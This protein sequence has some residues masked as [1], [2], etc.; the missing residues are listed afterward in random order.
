MLNEQPWNG[1]TQFER[2]ISLIEIETCGAEAASSGGGRISAMTAGSDSNVTASER[3]SRNAGAANT[4]WSASCCSVVFTKR[5]NGTS[6]SLRR[7][8]SRETMPRLARPCYSRL[9]DPA[10]AARGEWHGPG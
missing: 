1:P 7:Q 10:A 2:L 6:V 8:A 9:P 4:R 3:M 5:V